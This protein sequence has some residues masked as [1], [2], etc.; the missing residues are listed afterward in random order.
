MEISQNN[1]N[2]SLSH[3]L[4][5]FNEDNQIEIISTYR[6]LEEACSFKEQFNIK[7][8][9]NILSTYPIHSYNSIIICL[10]LLIVYGNSIRYKNVNI[11]ENYSEFIPECRNHNITILFTYEDLL[12]KLINVKHNSDHQIR[13]V[14]SDNYDINTKTCENFKS[15][16][17]IPKIGGILNIGNIKLFN[18][19][20]KINSVGYLS[21]NIN[22]LSK[23]KIVKINKKRKSYIINRNNRLIQVSNNNCGELVC[24][25]TNET[26]FYQYFDSKYNKN[27]ILTNAFKDD[28]KYFKSGY[29]VKK[30]KNGYVYII[31][32][33]E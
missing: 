24:E 4:Y 12:N 28:D 16:Y 22:V 31:E 32:K 9:D 6:I 10:G 21:S 18:N 1:Y 15:C 19:N 8:I 17:N 26:P 23:C 20:N 13:Y 3:I 25:I 5:I 30:D 7:N 14:I 2:L 29:L 33:F 11:N 27:K